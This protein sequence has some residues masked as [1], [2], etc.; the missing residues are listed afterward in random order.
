MQKIIFFSGSRAD[1]S[2]LKPLH[3]ILNKKKNIK[4]FMFLSGHHFSRKF[5]KTIFNK[6][7][8]F[9][10]SE[11]R[12]RNTDK[13]SIVTF[14]HETMEEFQKYIFKL[15]PRL[16][17]ILGDRYELYAAAVVAF[18]NNTPIIHLHG[19]EITMGANDDVTRHAITKLSNFHFV[20]DKN[21]RKRLVQLGENPKNIF[22]SKSIG[23]QLAINSKN[24][25]KKF[26]ALKLKLTNKN[27]FLIT[28]HPETYN[29][30]KSLLALHYLLLCL[31][32][33]NNIDLIF[34]I[35]NTDEHG[36]I[37]LKKIK[38]FCK[39]KKNARLIKSLNEH[40]HSFAKK[41]LGVIGN[42]SS[43][44]LEIPYLNVPVLNI[45][46]RQT[47]RV[48]PKTVI[49]CSN[50]YIDIKQ[51]LSKL[52]KQ[53]KIKKKIVK[54]SNTDSI[55]FITTKIKKLLNSKNINYKKKFYDI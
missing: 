53:T 4:S 43:G 21:C 3:F 41:S 32:D 13:N 29:L 42:S 50:K 28:F 15:K 6:K 47:G 12:L 55:N 9:I 48:I 40:Y 14:V 22:V 35:N 8:N 23:Y 5:E 25:K 7:K 10:K 49:N 33:I 45:G 39:N 30:E 38:K 27:F 51:G 2:L 31:K 36:E 44:I 19:G 37:F 26:I 1:Y 18:L 16:I 11:I 54:K 34:T 52:I 17:V 46:D 20:I 24:L